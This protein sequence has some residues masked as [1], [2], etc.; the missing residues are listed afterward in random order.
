MSA[1]ARDKDFAFQVM[2]HLTSDG[3]AIERARLARQV[4]P[5]PAAYADP[6]IAKDPVLAA[7]R[8]QLAHT[9]P[10]PM[11]P[12][13][14]MVWTPYKTALGEVV[15]GRAEAG[16]QLRA[17]EHEVQSYVAGMQKK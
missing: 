2:D 16:A 6:E 15:S 11:N 14:R 5:N 8:A 7:F 17:V 3:S 13:M 9:A 4:V 1:R 12:A 10:M